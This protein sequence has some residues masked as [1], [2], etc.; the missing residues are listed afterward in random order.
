MTGV[1]VGEDD[2]GTKR[3]KSVQTDKGTIRTRA[4]INAA[5]ENLKLNCIETLSRNMH[6]MC[7]SNICC[8]INI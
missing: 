6:T 3:V 1:Q 7:G 2:F 8:V 4:I 5:G